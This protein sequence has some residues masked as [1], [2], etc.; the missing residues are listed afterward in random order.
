MFVQF[1]AIVVLVVFPGLASAQDKPALK[2]DKDKV[3]YSIGLDIGTNFKRQAVDLDAKALAAGI[4]D[5][6]S[7]GK[8]LLAEDEVR[9][10]L[11]EFRQQM[12]AKAQ[13]AAQQLAEKNRKDG[14]TFL[15]ENKKKKGV[16]TLPSGLQYQ[17]IKEG[18]GKIPKA[19]ETVTTQYRGTLIDGTEFD[20]SY[21]RNEPTTF[22]VNG[23][24][25]GWTEALQLMKVGSTWQLFIPA[26]L[27]YGPQGAGQLIGPNATLIFEIELLSI[28]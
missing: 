20:S 6:L 24:I 18:T 7:G 14:E 12:G 22:P 25:K 3:S 5:G 8:P 23:V 19:S 1:V 27:A 21:K 16:I 11:D 28:K 26:S 13:Q 17:V 2:T 4:A 10:V 9:K 15:A